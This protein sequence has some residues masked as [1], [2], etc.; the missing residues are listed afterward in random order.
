MITSL[1]SFSANCPGPDNIAWMNGSIFSFSGMSHWGVIEKN[2][3]FNILLNFYI[4]SLYLT[5]K[6]YNKARIV[7][8]S[9]QPFL[10]GAR[11]QGVLSLDEELVTITGDQLDVHGLRALAA[12]AHIVSISLH[13]EL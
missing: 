10:D 2:K 5:P 11:S 9:I 8:K 3:I 7:W 4:L 13:A 6:M 1:V 12:P